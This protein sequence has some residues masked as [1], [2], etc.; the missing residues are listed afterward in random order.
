VR[1][2]SDEPEWL[3]PFRDIAEISVEFIEVIGE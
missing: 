2:A 1:F 3:L